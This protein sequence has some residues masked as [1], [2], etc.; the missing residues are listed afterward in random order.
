MKKK[1]LIS[2]LTLAWR[3]AEGLEPME[4]GKLQKMEANPPE[5]AERKMKLTKRMRQ[6]KANLPKMTERQRAQAAL[7]SMC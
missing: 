7:I 5:I 1:L 6:R 3:P 2:V 4:M